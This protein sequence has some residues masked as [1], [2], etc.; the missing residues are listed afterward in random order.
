MCSCHLCKNHI[1]GFIYHCSLCKFDLKI[2]HIFSSQ[3]EIGSHD[4]PFN[5]VS[6]PMS[7]VCD[8]RGIVGDCIPYLCTTCN[9]AV[10]KDCIS[11]PKVMKISRHVHPI[12]HIY[13]LLE[14]ECERTWDC[15]ICY[16]E[17]NVEY[18]S[19]YCSDC[20][21]IVHVNCAMYR[22]WLE[23]IVEDQTQNETL[24]LSLNDFCRGCNSH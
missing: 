4:H 10:H 14:N 12:S 13:F 24:I 8:A 11:L 21:Y 3:I 23:V 9:L 7:F 6:K 16:N 20:N 15:R 17:V 2:K 1:K 19:Y 18:G 22:N 5:L